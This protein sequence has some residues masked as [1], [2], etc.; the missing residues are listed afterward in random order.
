MVLAV[1]LVDLV[2]GLRDQEGAQSVAR[3]EG[4]RTLE[5]VEPTQRRELVEHQQQLVASG[6]AIR[7]IERFGQASADLV[8][9]QADQG[10]GAADVRGRHHQVQRH[11][12]IGI[13]QVGDA[14][15]AA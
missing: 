7:T 4:Q 15:V 5:E 8:E 14:P 1:G 10:L 12:V 11:R 3:H 2:E 9:N 6:N 13:D